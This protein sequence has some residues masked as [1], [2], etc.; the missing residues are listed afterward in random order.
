MNK[1]NEYPEVG[2]RVEIYF[3][4]TEKNIEGHHDGIWD[5]KEW[6][7]REP[8]TV[9]KYEP[10]PAHIT[11]LGWCELPDSRAPYAK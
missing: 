2:K 8:Y 11:P 7:F 5:G 1:I 4:N 3:K 9:D 10:I 6:K